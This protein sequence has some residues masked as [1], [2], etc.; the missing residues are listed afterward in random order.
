VY[1]R[2]VWQIACPDFVPLIE[3]NRIDDPYTFKTAE[4]Y[5]QPLINA[6]IDTLV[7]GCTHYPHL[8]HLFQQ[9]LPAHVQYVDPAKYLVR[10]AG[11]ELDLMGL[12]NN[13]AQE[14]RQEFWVSGN[15]RQ[16]AQVS[17]RWLGAEYRVG[18]VSFS[19]VKLLS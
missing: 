18:K 19:T 10:A 14:S 15:P 17:R 16:F 7:M 8:L 1:K 3:A 13:Y 12:K 4:A 5:L 9:I 2:Q 6:D 11:Q